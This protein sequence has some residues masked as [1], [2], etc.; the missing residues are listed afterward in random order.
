MKIAAS[1]TEHIWA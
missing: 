1:C